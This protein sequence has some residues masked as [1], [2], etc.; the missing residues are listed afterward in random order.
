MIAAMV[1]GIILIV[2]LLIMGWLLSP[3]FRSWTEK[4]KYTLL[5][6]NE[7]FERADAALKNSA[8]HSR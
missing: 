4:P 1:G 7:M 5:E 3:A 2:L 8:D 6:R